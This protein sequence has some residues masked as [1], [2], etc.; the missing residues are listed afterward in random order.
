MWS[1]RCLKCH[2]TGIVDSELGVRQYDEAIYLWF[3]KKMYI[4]NESNNHVWNSILTCVNLVASTAEAKEW[5][6]NSTLTSMTTTR[7]A[8]LK[9]GILFYIDSC[10][11]TA[12]EGDF[13]YNYFE[14]LVDVCENYQMT[15]TPTCWILGFRISATWRSNGATPLPPLSQMQTKSWRKPYG[16]TTNRL[17]P[18]RFALLDLD[19]IIRLQPSRC[20]K[21][22]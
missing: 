13:Y 12:Q 22:Y 21:C 1:W 19:V 6:S 5:C 3:S 2:N 11:T 4:I 14:D 8:S 7:S 15:S 9:A 17:R 16:A 20:R 18:I 10:C